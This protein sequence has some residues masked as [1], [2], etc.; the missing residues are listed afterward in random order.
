[1]SKKQF[2]SNEIGLCINLYYKKKQEIRFLQKFGY[3]NSAF[4]EGIVNEYTDELKDKNRALYLKK[5]R[6][7]VL[8]KK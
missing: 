2:I 5:K 6:Y 3:L 8:L 4:V 7:K 1:M